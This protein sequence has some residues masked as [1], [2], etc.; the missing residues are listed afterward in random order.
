[1]M[2]KII[3]CSTIRYIHFAVTEKSNPLPRTCEQK[4][5]RDIVIG[6]HI[7]QARVYDCS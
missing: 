2:T 1:M 5:K 4:K 6:K 7:I 3:V